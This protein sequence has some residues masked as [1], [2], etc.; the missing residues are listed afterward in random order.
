MIQTRREVLAGAAAVTAGL[1]IG[2]QIRQAVA[3]ARASGVKVSMC[4]WSLGK[5]TPEA[6]PLAKEIGL[7]GVQVSLGSPENRLWLRQPRIQ[8]EYLEASRKSGV[9]ISSLAMGLL[10]EIPLMSEP[11]AA[12]WAADAIEAAKA[13]KVQVIL[14]AFFGHGELKEDNATD[15]RRVTEVLQELAPRAEKAGVILGIE[16]Y[17]SAEGHLKI[18]DQVRSDAVQVYYDFFNS[19]ATKGYDFVKEVKLLGR[20]RI[21]EVHYKEGRHLLGASGKPDWPTVV[22]VLKEI[23]Y[24]RWA[25]LE[26][27]S[28][29]GN[30]VADT[31]R[32]LEYVR[33]LWAG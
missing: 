21:C 20:K 7:Q 6:F 8:E 9:A 30:M 15:M 23:G 1:A 31:R 10:N 24:D 18:L 17:M 29:S 4:D 2:T 33:K 14:L 32:N 5:T 25:T 13:L 3:E 19:H 26:T 27:S 11:R 12:I 28:P 16:S 22:K